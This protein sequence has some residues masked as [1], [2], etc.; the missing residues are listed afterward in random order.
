MKVRGTA[1]WT[2]ALGALVLS[3][4]TASMAADF[5]SKPITTV[6]PF[7]A[8]GGIDTIARVVA[9]AMHEQVGEPVI[10]ENRP[11][12]SGDIGMRYVSAAA[13]DG[14]TLL[15]TNNT[16]VTNAAMS[17][18][19]LGLGEDIVAVAALNTAPLAIAVHPDIPAKSI[20]EL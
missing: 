2:S 15:A 10:V 1:A 17:R 8:G 9:D 6:V 13:S 18:R 20:P 3:A 7:G 14:Y 5:P 12:A 11:G 19:P 16:M 4:A